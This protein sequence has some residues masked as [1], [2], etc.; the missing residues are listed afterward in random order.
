M[1]EGIDDSSD[2]ESLGSLEGD[3]EG[4][5]GESKTAEGVVVV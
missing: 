5:E 3:G 2:E 1:F 4:R